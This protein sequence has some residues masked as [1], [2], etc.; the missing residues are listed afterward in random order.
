MGTVSVTLPEA[1]LTKVEESRLQCDMTL[2]DFVY[3]ALYNYLSLQ[4]ELQEFF[5][6]PPEEDDLEGWLEAAL[7]ASAEMLASEFP[8][9]E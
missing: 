1:F 6:R 7:Q 8:W 9:E 2:D 3:R 5:N 4:Q